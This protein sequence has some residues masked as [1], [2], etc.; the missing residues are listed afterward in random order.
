MYE[1]NFVLED[2]KLYTMYSTVYLYSSKAY[3]RD[4]HLYNMHFI[5][6]E[7]VLV[8]QTSALLYLDS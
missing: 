6:Y 4:T 5:S 7:R 8:C 2:N 1:R 3:R